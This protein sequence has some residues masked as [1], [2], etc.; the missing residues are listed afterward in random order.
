MPFKEACIEYLD[1]LDASAK[2]ITSV[3]TIVNTRPIGAT[4]TIY[5]MATHS[6]LNPSSNPPA[7]ECSK[8]FL[9]CKPA[10]S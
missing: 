8:M 1:E 6:G 10:R 4:C 9:D 3:N 7:D 5:A 2:G